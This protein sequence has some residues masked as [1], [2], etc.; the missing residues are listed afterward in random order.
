MPEIPSIN[1][2]N[3]LGI[4]SGG[5]SQDESDISSLA[6][7]LQFAED[8]LFTA[9]PSVAGGALI[10]SRRGP[11]AKF[12]R[13][14]MATEIG[15]DGLIRYA[16]ENQFLISGGGSASNA[17]FFNTT[18]TSLLDPDGDTVNELT[19]LETVSQARLNTVMTTPIA[20]TYYSAWVRTKLGFPPPVYFHLVLGDGPQ[21][22]FSTEDW[23]I[24]NASGGVGSVEFGPD[25]WVKLKLVILPPVVSAVFKLVVTDGS[26]YGSGIAAGKVFFVGGRNVSRQSFTHYKTTGSP[27]YGPRFDYDPI[28]G[29]CLGL[30]VE[31]QRAN[32]LLQSNGFT[33][34]SWIFG[35]GAFTSA[36]QVAPD[37]EVNSFLFS[38]D[39]SVGPHRIFQSFIGTIGTTY[40]TS[41]FLKFAG[42]SQVYVETR[43]IIGNPYAVFNLQTGS[44]DL[45][46][47]GITA[48]MVQFPDGWWRCQI[49]GTANIA[50][51]NTLF[52]GVSSGSNSYMGSGSA[53]FYIFGAQV[54]AGPDSTSY[55][56]TAGT[57]P[58]TRSADECSITGSDFSGFYNQSEG[59]LFA[60]ATPKTVDQGALVVGT[61]TTTFLN[62]HFIY[63]TN[64]SITA[65]G[66]R[67]GATTTVGATS[68][69]N[70]TTSMDTAIAPS[71]LSYGYKLND[72]V[73]A[74]NGEII[75]TDAIGTMPTSTALRIGARDDG[76]Y[77]N[78]HIA[79]VRY[80]K[81]RLSNAKLQS[82]TTP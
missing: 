16:P 62:G 79:S 12:R 39:T 75:G 53:A 5:F 15:P 13:A 78:G 1:S 27:F 26:N 65:N 21:A 25:G 42:R 4:I 19:T 2:I 50:G 66:K 64:A 58:L 73:F 54:E 77:L 63:K 55:I 10:T 37:G 36:A 3:R 31:D 22:R 48:S 43:S 14:T 7:D 71:K 47:T 60:D 8:R 38:E 23:S 70:I 17:T 61:N 57:V 51:G 56:P 74:V 11:V 34:G 29:E 72:M 6:L 76:A 46:S 81:K 28:T 52:G 32:L 9:D 30:L 59:T 45:V 69:S 35:G 68:Q 18:P 40:T 20:P 80:Y 67:W 82:L 24:A 49:T 44:V 33:S 41:V